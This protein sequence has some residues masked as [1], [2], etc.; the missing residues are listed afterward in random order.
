MEL[1]FATNNPHKLAEMQAI[2]GPAVTLRS[3]R[4][5]GYTDDIIEDGTTLQQNALIKASYIYNNYHLP[6]FADDTGLEVD[7]LGGAP[8]V[9]TARYAGPQ[10]NPADNI[11]LLLRNMQGILNRQAQF[12]TVIALINDGTPLYFTG[13]IRGTIA[14]APSGIGGFGYDPLF[15]PEGHTQTFAQLPAEIK[16]QISH[17]A[18]AAQQLATYLRRKI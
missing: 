3:L 11:A 2:L 18:L 14:T 1:I 16:N 9:H 8:G 12:R 15:I 17:R 13:I 10:C 4:D 5:I 6:C 7:A